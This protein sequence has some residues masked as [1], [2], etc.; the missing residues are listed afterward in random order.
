MKKRTYTYPEGQNVYRKGNIRFSGGW[1]R[2]LLHDVDE[3]ELLKEL[4]QKRIDDNNMTNP[5]FII[6]EIDGRMLKFTQNQAR[7]KLFHVE[8][9]DDDIRS[10]D[11]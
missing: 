11:E 5:V 9:V 7:S 1:E 3:K 2:S 6:K 4:L 8:A 10:E